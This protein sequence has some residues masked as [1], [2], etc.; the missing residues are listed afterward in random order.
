MKR[1]TVKSLNEQYKGD[2]EVSFHVA[3]NGQRHYTIKHLPSNKVSVCIINTLAGVYSV[4][5]MCYI[6]SDYRCPLNITSYFRELE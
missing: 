4:I 2:F 3:R 5:E 1:P 6:Y